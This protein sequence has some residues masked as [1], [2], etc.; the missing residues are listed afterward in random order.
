MRIGPR[1]GRGLGGTFRYR[2]VMLG[3]WLLM[4]I[5]SVTLVNY[6]L[7]LPRIAK[8][9]GIPQ[10]TYTYYLGVLSYSLAYS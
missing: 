5:N 7:A 6:P 3:I 1:S 4:M 8:E 2:W 10:S 9:F